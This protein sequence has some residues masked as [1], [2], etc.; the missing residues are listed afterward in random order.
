MM[1]APLEDE[2]PAGALAGIEG[3]DLGEKL[4]SSDEAIT[5]MSSIG[6][7]S[8]Y[9]VGNSRGSERNCVGYA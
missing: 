7:L 3:L 1:E 5:F 9:F 8:V 4:K 6:E 2:T